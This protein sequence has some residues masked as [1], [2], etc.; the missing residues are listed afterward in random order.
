MNRKEFDRYL[1]R[2]F[3][4]CYH[5]GINDDTLVPQHRQGRGMGGS[6]A[7]HTPSNIITFCSDHNGK[8]ES[9]AIALL[10][11]KRL[12]W[13]LESWQDPRNTPVFC[14]TTGEWYLLTDDYTR[15][16]YNPDDN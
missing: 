10:R 7:R 16:V 3:G 11:A 14:M 5:C 12:G 8:I 13:R 1:R 15:Q 9:N 6:K 2:D 4:R